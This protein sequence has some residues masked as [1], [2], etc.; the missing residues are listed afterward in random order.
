MREWLAAMD[1]RTLALALKGAAPDLRNHVLQAMSSR[2]AEMLN[3]DIEVLGPVRA[4]D[5]MQAQQ[6][7][8]TLARR[9]EGEGKMIL[10][11]DHNEEFV[12]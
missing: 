8:V 9:L 1:K 2:A 3:E 10:K 7:A 11:A 12:V 6:E 4:R 5:V